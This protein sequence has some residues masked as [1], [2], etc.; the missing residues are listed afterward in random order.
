MIDFPDCWSR[1]ASQ[2][3]IDDQIEEIE[4]LRLQKTEADIQLTTL[5]GRHPDLKG[6]GM[7]MGSVLDFLEVQPPLKP[8]SDSLSATEEIH[9][10]PT[11]SENLQPLPTLN[12]FH[13]LDSTPVKLPHL[14]ILRADYIACIQ[15]LG[16][17]Q[18]VLKSA[19]DTLFLPTESGTLATSSARAL[20]WRTRLDIHKTTRTIVLETEQYLKARIVDSPVMIGMSREAERESI[21]THLDV[22]S[23]KWAE[24]VLHLHVNM[25]STIS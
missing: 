21:N 1:H 18:L 22:F 17:L 13:V 11:D 20:D 3:Q 24:P 15:Q 9:S 16:T 10:L 14:E 23:L 12:N 4:R 7:V 19:L 25:I 2:A 8:Q 5:L 6:E